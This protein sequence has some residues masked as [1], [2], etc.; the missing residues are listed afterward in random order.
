MATP[1]LSYRV[2]GLPK[3]KLQHTHNA[4]RPACAIVAALAAGQYSDE[5][6]SYLHKVGV[7]R[8]SADR[9][10]NAI[11]I[12]STPST[13]KIDLIAGRS[14]D[15]YQLQA[16]GQLTLSGGVL[17]LGCG[18]GKTI[19]AL[20]AAELLKPTLRAPR[21]W[22][23]APLNAMSSWK[24]YVPYLTES[25][26]TDVK[27]ISMD[28]LHKIAAE[29]IGGVIIYDEC[30][31]LG[32]SGARRTNA[33]HTTRLA[34]D[35]GICL[36]GTFLHGGIEKTLSMLDLAIPGA[37]GFSSRW[38]AGEHFGCLVRK[39]IGA[40]TV[41][42][43]EKP[44]GAKRAEF[45]DYIKRYVVMLSASSDSVRASL[46][47]PNQY[48]H[49]IE[50]ATPWQELP[51]EAAHTALT[52][53]A[54]TGVLP[55]AQAVA[56]ALCQAGAED[57]IAWLV[58]ALSSGSEQCV[59]FAHYTETLDA[60][61]AALD[62]ANITWTRVDGTS[63]PTSRIASR[64]A[65]TAGEARVFIGQI[66]AAGI[67]VDGLQDATTFSVTL[68]H[69]WRPDVY[70]QS[71][72]RTARRGQTLETNHFDLVSNQ[73]QAR[74]VERVRSGAEFNAEAEE[75]LQIRQALPLVNAR[76]V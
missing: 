73:L 39:R 34:F 2:V 52:M 57:K 27:I 17:A 3:S 31:L 24:P 55:N 4:D 6:M 28:S 11:R 42:S 25:G 45:F 67:G 13:V 36:T 75:W 68:D 61:V 23:V 58:D 59:V 71:L 44:G 15:D 30:H 10:A 19:T 1:A 7:P 47:I 8:S 70:A 65:F 48:I 14:L 20:G 37:A 50:L 22:I 51:D 54:E 46:T 74:V 12:G 60:L 18:L 43:L 49:T 38:A 21:L 29:P 26:W 33:A 64:A 53:H 56:H 66:V 69:C 40:R 9:W 35:V 16:I 76:P 5:A 72:A 41:T 62:Q 32:G 63:S